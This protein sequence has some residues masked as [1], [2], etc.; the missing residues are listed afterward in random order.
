MSQTFL[1]PLD[2]ATSLSLNTDGSLT[3]RPGPAYAHAVGPF[4]GITAATLLNAALS[5]SA[6]LGDPLCL[7][8]NYARPIADG[9]FR[10]E[11]V[12]VCTN[13]STQHWSITLS[14]GGKIATTATVAF[15]VRRDT[16][17][18][19]EVVSP[20]VPPAAALQRVQAGGMSTWTNNYD[21]RFVHGGLPD[22]T[23]VDRQPGSTTVQWIRD[24]PPRAMD[25]LSLAS[26]CDS[27][28]PRIFLRRQR[29]VPAGTISLTTYFHANTEILAAQ[30]ERPVLGIA[31]ASHF[32]L[33]YHDQSAEIW[34][35]NGV[36]LATSHQIG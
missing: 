6:R 9:E 2:R 5:H 34:S 35:D 8:A 24:D 30:G 36:L 3:G 26:I 25:F 12:P 21:L 29:P 10:V 27:F 7:T 18:S 28:F 14:Q 15:A 17:S 23:E 16:G 11:A 4:G 22:G 1:H 19:T 32:G 31:R 20:E 33:G 13:R